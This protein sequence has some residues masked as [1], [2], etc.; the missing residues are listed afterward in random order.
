MSRDG[1]APTTQKSAMVAGSTVP[2][3]TPEA[4]SF[5]NG[6]PGYMD[7]PEREVTMQP[8]HL[9]VYLTEDFQ[10]AARASGEKRQP[11]PFNGR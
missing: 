11:A 8:A 4:P 5:A 3:T 2:L 9:K 7:Q 1:A 6:H 10:E